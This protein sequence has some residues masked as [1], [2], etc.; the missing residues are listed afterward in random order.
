MLCEHDCKAQQEI[1]I[2]LFGQISQ[3]GQHRALSKN[4]V[5]FQAAC[6][7]GSDPSMCSLLFICRILSTQKAKSLHKASRHTKQHQCASTCFQT[8]SS[9]NGSNL[10]ESSHTSH[11]TDPSCSA[12]SQYADV[13]QVCWRSDSAQITA[14]YLQLIS[15]GVVPEVKDPLGSCFQRNQKEDSKAMLWAP[16]PILGEEHLGR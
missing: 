9:A 13:V 11:Q 2:C 7:G 16:H 5:R 3:I 4:C 8:S 14:Y 12:G 1:L 6:C 15:T 10:P